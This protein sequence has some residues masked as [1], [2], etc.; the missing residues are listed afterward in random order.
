MSY[1]ELYCTRNT[2]F[3]NSETPYEK[4]EFIV[5]GVPLDMTTSYMPGARFGPDSIRR[6]SLNI[7]SF[8]YET[9]VDV[10]KIKLTDIGDIDV[11]YSSLE[12][13]LDKITKVVSEILRDSKKPL[14]LGGEHTLTLSVCRA[15]KPKMMICFD[16]HLDLREEYAGAVISHASFMRKVVEERVA[17][18]ILF[19]GTRAVSQEEVKFIK[20][21]REH[22]FITA[23][24][25]Y[26][27]EPSSIIKF[28]GD[29]VSTYPEVY[30]SIDMDVLEPFLTPAVGNPEPGGLT[31]NFVSDVIENL[32]TTIIGADVTEVTPLYN[33]DLTSIYAAKLLFKVV[34][35]TSGFKP[36]KR[37]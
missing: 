27:S 36:R 21:T 6:A 19:I 4:A 32:D 28:I 1:R 30:I 15:I 29:T 13:T 25:V 18:K 22:S 3:L 14:I 24:E 20:N 12:L 33:I 23:K 31:Y 17:E 8:D 26:K 16:A 37:K 34:S 7:E 10:R 2:G 35:Y 9:G 5:L 11:D